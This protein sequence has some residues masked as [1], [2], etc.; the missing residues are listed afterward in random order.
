MYESDL[1]PVLEHILAA[2]LAES[3][4][5]NLYTEPAQAR[6]AFCRS[7]ADESLWQWIDP[8]QALT[9]DRRAPASDT[10]FPAGP[11]PG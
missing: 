10:A 6:A 5:V 2:R 8:Q 3:A 9:R 11:W 4:A 1:R 7:R